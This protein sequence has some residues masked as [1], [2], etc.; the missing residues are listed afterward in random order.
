[1]PFDLIDTHVHIWDLEKVDYPWLKGNKS[2]LNRSYQISELTP[3]LGNAGVSKGILVQA[4]SNF[5]DTNAML[6]VA[7]EEEWIQGV[8]GWLPLMEPD[9]TNKALQ[10][11]QLSPYFK[12]VRHMIHDEKD[13]A[14]LLQT[15]VVESLNQLASLGIPYDVVGIL[16]EHIHSALKLAEKIPH[17]K[18]VFD[19]L[20]QPP[21][22]TG[23]K[24]GEWGSLMTIASRHPNFY[25]KISGLGVTCGSVPFTKENIKPYI[26]F[27]IEQFGVDRCF[28]GGDWPVSLLAKDYA[29]TWN[30]YVSA[31]LELVG[32]KDAEKI[33]ASNAIDFYHLNPTQ[34]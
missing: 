18:M 21:I 30:I 2:I 8:V 26:A 11:Y 28:C 17:L 27:I 6:Q 9:N 23:D 5:E 24:F 14:W 34:S 33:F 3:Q 12:G 32:E 13:P 7:A 29:N 15:T 22:Q 10:Q 1:M 31:I 16:N 19:H 25:A 4:S 20:N